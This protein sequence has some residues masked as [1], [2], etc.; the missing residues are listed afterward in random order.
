[1]GTVRDLDTI[2]VEARDDE[3]GA[4]W[5]EATI[6]TGYTSETIDAS[7]RLACALAEQAAGGYAARA[8]AL[9]A[10]KLATAPFTASALISAIEMLRGH[11]LLRPAGRA[12]V[13]LLAILN[14]TDPAELAEELEAR[15][16][17]GYTTLKVKVGFDAPA[18]LERVRRI[19]AQVAGRALLRLDANQGYGRAEACR[20]A[21]ALD[22]AGIEL[23]EQPCAAADWEAAVAVA[24]VASVPMMLDE[25][26]YSLA[27]V[28][29]AAESGA[30]RYIKLKLMKLGGVDRLARGL[31]RIEE[32]GMLPVLGNGV[33][34]DVGCWMEGC[35]ARRHGRNAGEMN[36]FL[37]PVTSLFRAPI[38]VERGQMILDGP[39]PPL[40]ED[41]LS[42]H[43]VQT[44]RF[45]D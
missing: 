4:G 21:A 17:E 19:Q 15:L 35:V 26:I 31:R 33:A 38:R 29:R 12:A 11:E 44:R 37:K 22:P 24:R 28:E 40:D 10:A 2:L 34:A 13:P 36:G 42:R 32:L 45:P 25:S 6:L 20:F 30:A 41:A 3:G 39:M 27:D 7:W 14:A 18:D 5:G 16:A 43:G 8:E 9:A 1:M 23:L